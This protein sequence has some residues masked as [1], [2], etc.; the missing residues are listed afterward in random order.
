MK[1]KI[2]WYVLYVKNKHERK[3]NEALRE[4]GLDTFLPMIE[5]VRTWS[6]RKK[7]IVTPLFSCYVFVKITSAKDFYDAL[8]VHGA[9][10]FISF[11]NRYGTVPESEIE[12]V[13]I[14]LG[15]KGIS[16]V[17]VAAECLQKG[18]IRKIEHGPLEGMECEVINV[19]NLNKIIV[20][21]ESIGKNITATLPAMYLAKLSKAV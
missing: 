21:I 9:F 10:S 16:D 2:G 7:I 12:K 13:K 1:T 4:L 20:R 8:S 14:L 3:V 18:E 6:D 15:A 17:S 5:S 11:G 19:N